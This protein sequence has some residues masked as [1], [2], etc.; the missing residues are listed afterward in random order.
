MAAIEPSLREQTYSPA[1]SA[2]PFPVQ[3]PVFVEDGSDLVVTLGGVALAGWTYVGIPESG[4][5]GNPSTWVDGAVTLTA[6][7]T[8]VLV[9]AGRRPPRRVTQQQEG[10]GLPARDMNVELNIVTAV[11]QE[12][13][14]DLGRLNDAMGDLNDAVA[15]AE[16][17][18][19]SAEANRETV[20][21]AA[22]SVDEDRVAAENAAANAVGAA[23]NAIEAHLLVSDPHSGYVLKTQ[24]GV[25]NGVVPLNGSSKV[26]GAYL[27]LSETSDFIILNVTGTN[28]P[29]TAP[30]ATTAWDAAVALADAT[31]KEFRLRP[32][33][34]SA[35]RWIKLQPGRSWPSRARSHAACPVGI[36]GS[37]ATDIIF[38]QKLPCIIDGDILIDGGNSSD[39]VASGYVSGHIGMKIAHAVA[40]TAIAGVRMTG[41]IKFQNFGEY[42]LE[43]YYL[44]EP[45]FEGVSAERVGVGGTVHWSVKD[46][47]QVDGLIKNIF[48]GLP[49]GDWQRNAYGFTASMFTGKRQS[50]MKFV[51]VKIRDVPTWTGADSHSGDGVEMIDLDISGC[52]QGI[53]FENHI[54]GLTMRGAK[55]SGCKVVGFGTGGSATKDGLTCYSVGGIIVNSSGAPHATAVSI[56]RN[57]VDGCGERRPGVSYG[58]G[59]IVLRHARRPLVNDNT[60][61]TA[62]QIAIHLVGGT[63]STDE[64]LIAGVDN[65]VCDGITDHGGVKRGIVAGP[66]VQG[67]GGNNRMSGAVNATDAL[68]RVG[69]PVYGFSFGTVSTFGTAGHNFWN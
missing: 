36:V 53:A 4:F 59:A 8:G 16:A 49:A 10:R 14:R 6:P 38:D 25:A 65:N 39:T 3:F 1:N 24:K 19:A 60:I 68:G 64:I 31:G 61:S 66:Y 45:Y 52:S 18:A 57:E 7:A 11:Q 62:Q 2:G 32:T 69:S 29:A 15:Q 54:S 21:A 67:S 33:V 17:A 35:R 50:T 58:G 42:G 56:Q 28:H 40:D 47:V 44:D 37:V 12:Q 34:N 48:P 55:A 30:D 46:G 22:V 13:H 26:D 9:I 41:K 51:R 5:Y 23:A 63:A 43:T 27:D 20:E